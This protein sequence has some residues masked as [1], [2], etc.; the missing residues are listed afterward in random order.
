M[1]LSGEIVQP[2][3]ALKPATG[4]RAMRV[5]VV[6]DEP[7]VRSLL[8]KVL[9]RAGGSCEMAGTAEE[10]LH[11]LARER[12]DIAFLDLRLPG[13][14]GLTLAKTVSERHPD[15]A[16]VMITGVASFDLA[17]SAMQA[18]AV[19][20]L[21]K[22][23]AADRIVHAYRLAVQRR[24]LQLDAGRAQRLQQTIA[25]R[26]V[27][28][29]TL[30]TQP[31]D[32]PQTAVMTFLATLRMRSP[33]AA[34]HAERVAAMSRQ[35]AIQLE[36]PHE[37]VAFVWRAAAVHDIGKLTL[38]DALFATDRPLATDEIQ[39]VRRHP[40][41][42]QDLLRSIPLLADCGPVVLAQ[43]EHYDGSGWPMGL[44][45][46]RIPIGA[47]IIGI[48]NVFDVMTHSR[49]YAPQ[50]TALEALQEIEACRGTQYDPVVANA[51]FA[52]FEYEPAVSDW[53]PDSPEIETT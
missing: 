33:E 26:S 42:G 22:P 14:D 8:A 53:D 12:F 39:V 30:L 34:A 16:L 37:D 23:P 7:G 46:E 29:R 5:L 17:V 49:P 27:E 20:Y 41:F 24:R 3:E 51:L 47:R 50:Q 19:D 10:A 31:F 52:L 9:S 32:S 13:M 6:D 40:E 38:P 43:L 35:M 21:V 1:G 2:Q 28:L 15:V 44:R 36:L 48:A 45:A 4:E 25:E 18:G 11:R